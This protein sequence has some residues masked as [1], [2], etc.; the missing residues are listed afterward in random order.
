MSVDISHFYSFSV[1]SS[2]YISSDIWNWLRVLKI[3]SGFLRTGSVFLKIGSEFF[4]TGSGLYRLRD[5]K[6]LIPHGTATFPRMSP[7]RTKET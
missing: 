3:G 4:G 2:I 7:I 5:L 6:K 1:I